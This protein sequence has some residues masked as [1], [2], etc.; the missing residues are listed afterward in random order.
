MKSRSSAPICLSRRKFAW[1][2]SQMT[3]FARRMLRAEF[4]AADMGI[5]GVNFAVAESGS[6]C[7]VE[8]EGNIR[9]A[10][11]DATEFLRFRCMDGVANVIHL[12]FSDPWPKT[13][14][15]KR[16]VVQDQTLRE[17]HRV[18]TECGELRLVTDHDD[19]W[20]WYREHIARNAEMFAER[21]FESP[22]SAGAGEL[23]GTN[24]ERKYKREGR[25][26]HATTLVRK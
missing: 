8:N 10:N 18:L 2:M 21:T 1:W 26:F 12:Y 3:A 15:H 19:L 23:V 4:L 20:Q 6:L 22:Q 25:P 13:R 9:L 24:F 16:R 11:C 7:L 17:F 14:H 5:S